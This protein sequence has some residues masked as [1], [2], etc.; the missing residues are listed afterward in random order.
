MGFLAKI[1][2]HKP[3][4]RAVCRKSPAA[5]SGYL[6]DVD[7]EAY[8]ERYKKSTFTSDML[9]EAKYL[10]QNANKVKN[11]L[12]PSNT[13]IYIFISNEKAIANW[14]KLLS[15]YVA[16]FKNGKCMLLD[17]GHYVHAYEPVKIAK[18]INDYISGIL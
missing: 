7:I 16:A 6:T 9:N 3:F 2:I 10:R 17:C 15:D 5:Q 13:P 8:I 1:G 14:S 4:S 12:I 11:G 18:E